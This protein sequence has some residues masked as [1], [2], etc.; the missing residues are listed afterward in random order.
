MIGSRDNANGH[1]AVASLQALDNVQGT[2]EA[3]QIDVTDDDS[4]LAAAKTVGEKHGRL[5]CLVNNAGVSNK[6]TNP[7]TQLRENLA[8]NTVGP[9]VVTDAFVGLLKKSSDPRLI[10]V[11]TSLAS[12]LHATDP[13]SMYYQTKAS[14][15]YDYYRASKAALNMIMVEYNKREGQDIKIWGGDPGWLATD[16]ANKE[17]ME[18]LGAPHPSV[19]GNE[20]A[21]CIKGER[22]EDVGKVVGKYGVQKW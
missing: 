22:D 3:I 13:S 7:G 17:V 2:V 11:T 18:K 14:Y 12:L 8:V 16:L 10:F 19:G 6:S 9:V 1:E 21:R 5:D 4:I 15:P 20:I